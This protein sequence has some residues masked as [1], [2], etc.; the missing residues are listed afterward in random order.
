M[1]A[2]GT[3]SRGLDAALLGSTESVLGGCW[4]PIAV[5][6]SIL[7][8][9]PKAG[10]KG[11]KERKGK[12]PQ[13][14]RVRA[15]DQWECI[16]TSS[17]FLRFPAAFRIVKNR[18][19]KSERHHHLTG[20]WADSFWVPSRGELLFSCIV[21]FAPNTLILFSLDENETI[22]VLLAEES[23]SVI[24]HPWQHRNGFS[25]RQSSSTKCTGSHPSSRTTL[26]S[27]THCQ[28]QKNGS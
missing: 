7:F 3:G 1:I 6:P 13:T 27:P 22:I 18:E 14:G 26:D 8:W 12:K 15:T 17:H 10:K 25:I 9:E 19:C 11:K 24:S 4:S 20:H 28:V 16:Y 21:N 2:N 5:P 23:A